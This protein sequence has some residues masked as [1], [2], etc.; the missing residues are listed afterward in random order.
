MG[1]GDDKSAAVNITSIIKGRG[2]GTGWSRP[3]PG[4]VGTQHEYHLAEG[5]HESAFNC[6]SGTKYHLSHFY[7]PPPI[8][9]LVLE[10][11]IDFK[12]S[13]FTY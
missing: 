5:G 8:I 6:F 12:K 4:T 3:P 7:T 1:G 9:S 10:C 13:L 11:N 2:M